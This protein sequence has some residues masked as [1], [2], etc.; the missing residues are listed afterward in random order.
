VLEGLTACAKILFCNTAPGVLGALGDYRLTFQLSQSHNS[1]CARN[2][3]PLAKQAL[4]GPSRSYPPY[5]PERL[6]A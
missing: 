6:R 3:K 2:F 1:E 5:A 4:S